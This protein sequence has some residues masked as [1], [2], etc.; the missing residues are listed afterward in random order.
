MIPV[1]QVRI[2][3]V[4]NFIVVSTPSEDRGRSYGKFHTHPLNRKQ[5]PVSTH[6]ALSVNTITGLI[7]SI[8]LG[9]APAEI[10]ESVCSYNPDFQILD[11]KRLV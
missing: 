5:C 6:I 2:V 9:D 11:A 8:P 3:A 10:M 4:T 7:F 1:D